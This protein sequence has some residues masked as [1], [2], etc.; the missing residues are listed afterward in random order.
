VKE[1]KEELEKERERRREEEV[2]SGEGIERS[3]LIFQ[4]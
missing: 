2:E 1:L 4:S 3:H